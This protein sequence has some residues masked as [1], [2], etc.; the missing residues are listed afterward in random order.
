M[1]VICPHI[2]LIK[3]G[4]VMFFYNIKRTL[5]SVKKKHKS[6][7]PPQIISEIKLFLLI[8]A[9]FIDMEIYSQDGLYSELTF[10]T[11]LTLCST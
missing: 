8:I 1:L 4:I 3:Y 11:G 2:F 6:G 10:G 7:L 9:G 5:K